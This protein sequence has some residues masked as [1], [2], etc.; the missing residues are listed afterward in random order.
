M[1][2]HGAG[3]EVW[4]LRGPEGL[5][6]RVTVKV[7]FRVT[8]ARKVTFKGNMVTSGNIVKLPPKPLGHNEGNKVT[9]FFY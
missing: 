6:E 7:T 9:S 2:A 4:V 5:R 8:S 3:L 1:E